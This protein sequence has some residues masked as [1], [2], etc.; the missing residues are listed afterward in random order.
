MSKPKPKKKSSSPS[1]QRGNNHIE[2]IGS[3]ILRREVAKEYDLSDPS[4]RSAFVETEQWLAFCNKANLVFRMMT[5]SKEAIAIAATQLNFPFPAFIWKPLDKFEIVLCPSVEFK[6]TSWT[7]AYE[8]CLSLPGQN[9]EVYRND[10][11]VLNGFDR[12]GEA[13]EERTFTGFNARIVQ[14]EVDHLY[15]SLIIDYSEDKRGY[16]D[17]IRRVY[18]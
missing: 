10:Q 8:G 11:V 16:L 3:P 1:K 14:H 2:K 9:I 5:R 4:L 18:G 12:Y 15:G 7:P 6:G 17:K 13:F